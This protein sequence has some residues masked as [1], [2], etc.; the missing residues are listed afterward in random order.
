MTA[1]PMK[2]PLTRLWWRIEDFHL[3]TRIVLR[4]WKRYWTEPLP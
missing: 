2:R 1:L 3:S 4:R